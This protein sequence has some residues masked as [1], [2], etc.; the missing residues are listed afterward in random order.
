[1]WIWGIFFQKIELFF[2]IC[3]QKAG[4]ISPFFRQRLLALLQTL[5]HVAGLLENPELTCSVKAHLMCAGLPTCNA[6]PTFPHGFM[7]KIPCFC[8]YRY[9]KGQVTPHVYLPF[10]VDWIYIQNMYFT[11]VLYKSDLEL[12]LFF[13]TFAGKKSRK[14]YSTAA[15][16]AG[17]SRYLSCPRY[18]TFVLRFPSD[19]G[20]VLSF[21]RKYQIAFHGIQ[22]SNV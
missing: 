13:C 15:H 11:L 18:V 4:R 20:T 9:I 16:P 10:Q 22:I 5:C 7:H 21:H 3:T 19:A 8:T 17:W 6:H 12:L 14:L 1:M 2:R